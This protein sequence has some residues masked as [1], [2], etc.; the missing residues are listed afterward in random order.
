MSRVLRCDLRPNDALV[1]DYILDRVLGRMSEEMQIIHDRFDDV[2]DRLKSLE[3]T[4]SVLNT[5]S[6]KKP[7]KPQSY[8]PQPDHSQHLQQDEQ[9]VSDRPSTKPQQTISQTKACYNCGEEG[10]MRRNCPLGWE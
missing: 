2:E 7:P 9:S 6:R 1:A 3:A 4:V 5:S 10:H 8:Q